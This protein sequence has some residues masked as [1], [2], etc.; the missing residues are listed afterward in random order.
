MP[1]T[2]IRTCLATVALLAVSPNLAA[3]EEFVEA[4]SPYYELIAP[5]TRHGPAR[6][7]Y[8]PHGDNPH[9]GAPAYRTEHRAAADAPRKRRSC[10]MF[11]PC[12]KLGRSVDNAVNTL[13]RT[14]F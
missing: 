13:M 5:A 11:V 10:S 12:T 2:T 3:A 7:S 9:H 8:Y 6:Y 14:K 1:H 4:S